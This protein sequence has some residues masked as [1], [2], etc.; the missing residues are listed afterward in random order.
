MTRLGMLDIEGR[1]ELAP[2]VSRTRYSDGTEVWVNRGEDAYG[3]L[4]AGQFRLNRG[5]DG[6]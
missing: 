6:Q 5:R 1:W 2:G 4:P 3:D